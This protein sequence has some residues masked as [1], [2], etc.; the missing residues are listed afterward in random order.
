M[1][2]AVQAD[3]G[4]L[5][6]NVEVTGIDTTLTAIEMLG[7]NS[8]MLDVL[9]GTSGSSAPQIIVSGANCYLEAIRATQS[10]DAGILVTGDRATLVGIFAASN[11]FTTGDG[12][13]FNG[14]DDSVLNGLL[15]TAGSVG[16]SILNSLRVQCSDVAVRDPGRNGINI[17]GSDFC[18]VKGRVWDAGRHGIRINNG[19]QNRIEVTVI[20]SGGDTNNTYD[21]LIIEGASNRNF[22]QG[23]IFRGRLTGNDTRYGVNVGGS[24]ECNIVVGNDLG[25][26]DVYGTDALIVTAANTQLFY[27]ADALYGDNYTDCGSGS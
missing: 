2:A 9:C 27:P 16:L 14:S 3:T 26:P 20:D 22:I 15:S 8:R 18:S 17:D 7:N 5:I 11:G 23:C 12:V 24:G 1:V 13:R 21:N 10:S 25:D 6:E 4:S 19:D